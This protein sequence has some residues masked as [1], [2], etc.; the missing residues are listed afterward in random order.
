M[1]DAA[2]AGRYA[3]DDVLGVG[4]GWTKVVAV[5]DARQL[6]FSE[7]STRSP[8]RLRWSRPEGFAEVE[9]IPR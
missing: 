1:Q 4:D 7:A 5:D 6:V 8:T 2:P 9:E 3:R